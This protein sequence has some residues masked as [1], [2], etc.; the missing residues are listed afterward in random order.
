MTNYSKTILCLANSRKISGR[1]IAG[2]ELID[3][4]LGA[5]VRPVS[6]RK[7]AELSEEERWFENGRDPQ[8]LDIIRVPMIEPRPH[9][10]QIENHLI[11]ADY[12]WSLEGRATWR[13]AHAAVDG[14]GKPLWHNGSS[15]YNGVNDRV[16]EVQA[17]PKD[18]SLR[19]IEV[20]DLRV[21]VALEGAEFG[22]GK[23]KVRGRF[24]HDGVGH[25]LSITDPLVERRYLSG[26]DGVFPLD[27]ALL[28]IS[29]GEP[30]NDWAYK[31]IAAVITPQ[32]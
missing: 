3:G 13:Q 25:Y 14:N 19:L 1:C 6:N 28:C 20:T 2:R 29:L 10:F 8:V 12:Y 24:T 26:E 16:A 18:G 30:F 7:S 15:S 23:R 21:C 32:N 5:W 9:L 4:K 11:D 27:H 31:L 22:N 17:I